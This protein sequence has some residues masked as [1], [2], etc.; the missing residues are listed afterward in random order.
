MWTRRLSDI[1]ADETEVDW[2]PL[3]STFPAICKNEAF[4]ERKDFVKLCQDCHFY[5]SKFTKGDADVIFTG[6]MD[7]HRRVNMEGLKQVARSLALRLG[8]PVAE[9]LSRMALASAR[10]QPC[11]SEASTAEP[12]AETQRGDLDG[13]RRLRVERAYTFDGEARAT[14]MSALPSQ[15]PSQTPRPGPKSW[16]RRNTEMIGDEGSSRRGSLRRLEE[17]A[18]WSGVKQAF[19]QCGA[20]AGID[21]ADFVRLC[22]EAQLFDNLRFGKTE[23]ELIFSSHAGKSRKLSFEQFQEAL[24]AV[25]LRKQCPITEVQSMVGCFFGRRD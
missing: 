15:S 8:C 20:P 5:D 24:W 6:A 17:E 4:M 10:K 22:K 19:T 3:E 25:A 14:S 11:P 18:D 16:T 12:A 1:T 2:E 7:S 13:G 23:T 9:V 21:L